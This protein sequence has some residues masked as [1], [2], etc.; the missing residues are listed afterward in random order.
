MPSEAYFLEHVGETYGYFFKT[1]D[2]LYSAKSKYQQIAVFD[3]PDL[4]RVFMLD[5]YINF[6]TT[7]EAF[8][9]EPMAHIPLGMVDKPKNILI[10]GGGDFG[11][12]GQVLKHDT[13]ET[14]DLCEIDE[15]IP[16]VCC[17]FFPEITQKAENDKRFKLHILD[18]MVFL[19]EAAPESLDAIIVDS[20]DPFDTSAA[21]P[22]ISEEFYQL[23]HR[24]LRK[25]G[26]LMQLMADYMFFNKTWH[27]VLPRVKKHFSIDNP[28]SITIPLYVT[29]TWGFLLAGKDRT[30]LGTERITQEY[31]DRLGNI[32][33]MTPELVKGWFSIPQYVRKAITPACEKA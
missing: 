31:L 4:G 15:E 29:G 16:K 7:M 21:F 1:Q 25:K 12:A 22:L 8:Y 3:S 30:E 19:R 9:H 6:T 23:V 11:V 24:V 17:R 27:E 18:G 20:T 13:V 32:Q 26:V 28:I 33:T 14:L 10:I 2:L 5:H